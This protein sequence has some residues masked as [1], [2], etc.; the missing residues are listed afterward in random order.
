MNSQL[1]PC[2]LPRGF[3]IYGFCKGGG[4]HVLFSAWVRH[5]VSQKQNQ[6]GKD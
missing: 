3:V 1:V 5:A 4:S 6:N 2:G